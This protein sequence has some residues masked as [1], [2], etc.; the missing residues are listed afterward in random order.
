MKKIKKMRNLITLI[1]VSTLILTVGCSKE[2]DPPAP[3]PDPVIVYQCQDTRYTGPNCDQQ[4]T[5]SKIVINKVVVTHF[6]QYN[7]GNNWDVTDF[8]D[9]RPDLFAQMDNGSSYLF[10]TDFVLDANFFQ[11]HTFTVAYPTPFPFELTNPLAQYN[12]AAMDADN[13]PDQ[14][15]AEIAFVPYNSTNGFPS[16]LYI[17]NSLVGFEI[18]ITYVF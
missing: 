17:N 9:Y 15:M 10:Y 4:K 7:L 2:K 12:I 16:V 8:G 14:L 1:V 13:G 5:P 6:P 3:T 11:P 18:Y